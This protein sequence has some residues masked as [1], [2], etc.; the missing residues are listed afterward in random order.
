MLRNCSLV[1]GVLPIF[2]FP[3]CRAQ[4]TIQ[5]LRKRVVTSEKLLQPYRFYP[6]NKIIKS[7]R[8]HPILHFQH[9][10]IR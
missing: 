7:R 8:I 9:Q 10:E 4:F 5:K 1:V 3:E 2:A 6:I